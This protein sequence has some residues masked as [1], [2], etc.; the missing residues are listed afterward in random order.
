[1]A[2]HRAKGSVKAADISDERVYIAIVAS[3]TCGTYHPRNFSW[4]AKWLGRPEPTNAIW[5]YATTYDIY[6]RLAE[7]PQKVVLAKLR[8][9]YSKGRLD[10]ECDCGC[11]GPWYC[12]LP[13]ISQDIKGVISV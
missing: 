3:G 6:D 12:I 9:M 8:Q 7:W 4:A 1:M 13:S 2:H 11:H 5:W 10:S